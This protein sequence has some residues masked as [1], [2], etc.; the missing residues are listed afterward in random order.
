MA[1]KF[2]DLVTCIFLNKYLT[3]SYHDKSK[4]ELPL[5][6][7]YLKVLNTPKWGSTYFWQHLG[8]KCWKAKAILQ[9]LKILFRCICLIVSIELNKSIA[10]EKLISI[11]TCS[12]CPLHLSTGWDFDMQLVQVASMARKDISATYACNLMPRHQMMATW[13]LQTG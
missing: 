9:K 4:I 2:I 11:I 3:F 12:C 1:V 8:N 5:T 13:K 10:L 7:S 6:F